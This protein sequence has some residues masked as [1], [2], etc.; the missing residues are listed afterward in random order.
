MDRYPL[1][2]V[3]VWINEKNKFL[4][5]QCHW[6]ADT[7]K[8]DGYIDDIKASMPIQQFN[9]EFEIQWETFI[10]KPVY[11]DWVKNVHST[12]EEIHPHTGLPLLLGIDQ[13]LMPA[14]IVAQM[15]GDTLAVL[16]EYTAINM[17]AERF[18]DMVKK[19]LMTRYPAWDRWDT[20]Y[21]TFMDPAGFNK[22]DTDETTY[23]SIWSKA[24]FRPKPGAMGWEKRRSSVEHFLTKSTKTGPC[25]K[26]SR[27][28]CPT[29]IKGFD[30]GF[31]YPENAFN[32]EPSKIRP[33][34][35]E[36]S[37][38]HDGFQYLCSGILGKSK[39]KRSLVPEPQYRVGVR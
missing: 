38:P 2:G 9:Q 36:H 24:G 5:Y 29:L 8:R 18:S 7:S 34:K 26:V 35:D 12:G 39:T 17:G 25:L 14:C 33:L 20:D 1:E 31:R 13:G 32:V 27:P 28:G 16:R 6:S 15:Q 4:I 10:G 21:I 23:A 3:E 30:G 11:M 19:D 37:H 22:K